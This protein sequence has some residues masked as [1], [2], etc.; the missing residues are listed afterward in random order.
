MTAPEP[1]SSQEP[2]IE[3]P[4]VKNLVSVIIPVYNRATLIPETLDCVA[5]QTYRPIEVVVVDDGSTDGSAQ[6]V[7]DWAGASAEDDLAL[8]LI[9]QANQGAPAARNQGLEAAR[10]EFIQFLDSDDLLHE[11]KIAAQTAVFRE[12]PDVDYV[13]SGWQVVAED[14]ETVLKDWPEDF[15]AGRDE[16]IDMLL[17]KI[18]GFTLP[19]CT[20][21]GLYHRRLCRRIP[22]WD[23]E[24]LKMQ[25]RYYNLNMLLSGATVRYVPRVHAYHRMH[26]EGRITDH[27]RDPQ[28]LRNARQ[29]WRK[30]QIRL[31][32]CDE[33]TPE[34]KALLGDVH[35]W[36]ARPAYATGEKKLGRQL[37][38]E[39]A[40]L[41]PILSYVWF[42]SIACRVLYG[43]LG[44]RAAEAIL[45][46]KKRFMCVLTGESPAS[47]GSDASP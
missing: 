29:T 42:K 2:P 24:L 8:N 45:G 41:A 38:R 18:P 16:L 5:E 19:L 47:G 3:G 23:V 28:Y 40:S 35:Y 4:G 25:E 13:F 6:A 31:E 11:E 30:I 44:V 15:S 26:G 36:I 12:E 7:R 43:L 21:N 33:L 17:F 9:E 14:G 32:E 27:D 37:L 39:A 22:P 20:H 1:V 10:G 34:R 46:A